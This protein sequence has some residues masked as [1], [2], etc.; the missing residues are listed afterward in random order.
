[1]PSQNQETGL[2]TIKCWQWP[3]PVQQ[4][5][6]T[7]RGKS[8]QLNSPNMQ[9]EKG[10]IFVRTS[11]ILRSGAGLSRQNKESTLLVLICERL[12][13]CMADNRMYYRRNFNDVVFYD[14]RKSTA[15]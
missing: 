4:M 11:C 2:Y 6:Q 1:M 8:V 12:Q 14:K 9:Q 15:G 13:R 3:Y 5:H 10:P 7:V